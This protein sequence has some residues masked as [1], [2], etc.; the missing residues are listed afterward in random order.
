[1]LMYAWLRVTLWQLPPSLRP[2]QCHLDNRSQAQLFSF[3]LSFFLS[4][5][6]FVLGLD[7]CTG[8]GIYGGSPPQ[9]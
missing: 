1:M 5:F 4:F 2:L 3:F 6:R 7:M 9:S 8:V